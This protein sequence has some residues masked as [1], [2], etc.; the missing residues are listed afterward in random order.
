MRSVI[1]GRT[2]TL[3][4][5]NWAAPWRKAFW[6]LEVRLT[7]PPRELTGGFNLGGVLA[8]N[9]RLPSFGAFSLSRTRMVRIRVNASGHHGQTAAARVELRRDGEVIA[10]LEGVF[11]D[12]QPLELAR[13]LPP[14]F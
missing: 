7:Q 14:G 13:E 12:D 4:G 5:W 6:G 8:E 9:G 1:A 10:D 2:S 11:A 3:P